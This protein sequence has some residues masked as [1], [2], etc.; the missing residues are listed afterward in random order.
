MELHP[1][2]LEAADCS[3]CVFPCRQICNN[4]MKTSFTILCTPEQILICR[5]RIGWNILYRP[6]LHGQSGF[7]SDL[8]FI[9]LL[10]MFLLLSALKSQ[11]ICLDSLFKIIYSRVNFFLIVVLSKEIKYLL[12]YMSSVFFLLRFRFKLFFYYQGKQIT[13]LGLYVHKFN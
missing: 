6:S 4:E 12:K 5:S 13:M 2:Q 3:I 9:D 7:C 8:L 1:D 11:S 10:N